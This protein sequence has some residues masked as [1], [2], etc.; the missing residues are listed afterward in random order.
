M[1]LPVGFRLGPYE[2]LEAVGAGGMGEVYRARDTKLNRSVAIKLILAG[3]DA[4]EQAQRRLLGEARAAAGLDHP[5]ICAIHEVSEAEGR[6]F[7]VMQYVEGET[8]QARL[9]RAPLTMTESLSIAAHVVDALVEAHAHGTIHRDIKPSN[10]MLTPRGGVKVLDFGLAMRAADASTGQSV[11]AT[12]SVLTATGAVMGTVPYMSPEQL[13]GEPLDA[14]SD[15]FSFGVMLYE[16]VSGQPPFTAANSASLMS[17]ILTEDPQPLARYA[18]DTPPELERIVSK[19]MRKDRDSRYQT[20]KDL[21][22]DVRTLLDDV[23]TGAARAR[24]TSTGTPAANVIGNDTGTVV[25]TAPANAGTVVAAPPT[26]LSLRTPL[27]AIVLLVFAGAGVWFYRHRTNV[28][29]ATAQVPRIEALAQSRDF[30]QAYDLAQAARKYLPSDPTITRLMPSLADT[31]SVTTS[32]TSAQ[33]YLK[34]FAPDASGAVPPRELIGATPIK[35]L[36]IARGEY[37]VSIEKAGYVPAEFTVSG[38]VIRAGASTVLPPPIVVNQNLFAQGAIPDGMVFVPGGDYRL[39]NWS[40][41]TETRVKLNDFFIDRYEVSNRDFQEFIATGGYLKK[42][43]WEH[44]FVKDGKTLTWEEAMKVL[45]D[46]T[47]LPGPRGW[48]GQTFPE[49]KADHPVTGITWYEAAAYAAFRGKQLPTIFQ[50]EKA[51]RAGGSRPSPITCRGAFSILA[52]RSLITPTSTTPG[53]F[54]CRA[55]NSG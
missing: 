29:W 2:I 13:R 20:G 19:A 32:P 34:R 47:D 8:L 55:P 21:L 51:A 23:R 36:Q 25:S 40:R 28:V 30:F 41:P 26:R 35:N 43:Y 24:A 14:R 39:V 33:V 54:R 52:I 50:W 42:Q 22:I 18:R 9:K 16:M 5:N 11:V 46:R 49:A 27:I 17:A 15:L 7:I 31:L 4:S 37:V 53:P 45:I 38:A 44:P 1:S 48:S 3:S 12:Q 6:A 10:V